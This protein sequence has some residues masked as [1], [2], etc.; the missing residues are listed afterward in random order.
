M[1][2]ITPKQSEAIFVEAAGLLEN[3]VDRGIPRA[4]AMTAFIYAVVYSAIVGRPDADAEGVHEVLAP[5][6]SLETIREA[7]KMAHRPDPMLKP[8]LGR[9]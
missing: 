9:A 8:P 6:V 2:E 1:A 7:V 5:L 4:T 3:M